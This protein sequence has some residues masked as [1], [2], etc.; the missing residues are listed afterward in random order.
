M[1]ATPPT[2]LVLTRALLALPGLFQSTVL[3]DVFHV[4]DGK[5]T[6]ITGDLKVNLC[7]QML[8]VALIGLPG[9]YIAMYFMESLGRKNIQ[10][11]GF[12]FMAVVF[13]ILGIWEDDLEVCIPL[14]GPL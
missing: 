3:R 8:V 9:Y 5:S 13:A 6:T 1:S 11:Q 10:L 7:W 14:A 4:K 12:F 2:R